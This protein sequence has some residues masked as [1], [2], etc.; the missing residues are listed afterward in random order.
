MMGKKTLRVKTPTIPLIY[1]IADSAQAAISLGLEIVDGGSVSVVLRVFGNMD[2]IYSLGAGIYVDFSSSVRDDSDIAAGR[3]ISLTMEG[4]GSS[5]T[6]MPY[7]PLRGKEPD[8]S[9]FH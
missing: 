6:S 4:K 1:W 3:A 9:S 8:L 5:K 2:G 7:P